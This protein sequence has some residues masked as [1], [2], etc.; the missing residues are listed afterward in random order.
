MTVKSN[1][2]EGRMQAKKQPDFRFLRRPIPV[3]GWTP[4]I[5]LRSR[6]LFQKAKTG[7]PLFINPPRVFVK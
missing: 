5:S 3:F 1:P 7:N 6:G 4:C 2:I